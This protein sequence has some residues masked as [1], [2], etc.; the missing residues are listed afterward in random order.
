MSSRR[1]FLAGT[2]GALSLLTGCTVGYSGRAEPPIPP[3]PAPP[4]TLD[5]TPLRARTIGDAYLLDPATLSE[6][7]RGV[8]TNVLERGEFLDVGHEPAF[9]PGSL[10]NHGGRVHRLQVEPVGDERVVESA[11]VTVEY[12]PD[13]TWQAETLAVAAPLSALSAVDREIVETV[14]RTF[15]PTTGPAKSRSPYDVPAEGPSRLRDRE[16]LSVEHGGDG[17]RVRATGWARRTDRTYRYTS[18]EAYATVSVL[19]AEARAA[20]AVRV[21]D[22]APAE[23]AFLRAA[24]DAPTEDADGRFG[25]LYRRLTDAPPAGPGLPPAVRLDGRYYAVHIR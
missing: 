21:D 3:E 13:A 18:V 17:Y 16:T 23:L 2:A 7:Q 4:F 15:P 1:T 6:F 19:G 14:L 8:L 11:L 10:V 25:R 22:L 12:D 5:L 9:R 20:R 24:A